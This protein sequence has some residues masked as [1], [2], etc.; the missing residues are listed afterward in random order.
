[1][2][3]KQVSDCDVYDADDDCDNDHENNDDGIDDDNDDVYDNDCDVQY[4]GLLTAYHSH[5]Y[6]HPPF[7]D[8]SICQML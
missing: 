3:F 8:T 1:M 5:L 4:A 6:H 7:M 2:L